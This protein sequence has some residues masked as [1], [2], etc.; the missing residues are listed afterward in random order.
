MTWSIFHRS[1][2]QKY[3]LPNKVRPIIYCGC[4]FTTPSVNKRQYGSII[5]KLQNYLHKL[6]TRNETPSPLGWHI[7]NEFPGNP[8]Q[9]FINWNHVLRWKIY[10]E[11]VIYNGVVSC[12]Q[13]QLWI[14]GWRSYYK[15][16]LFVKYRHFFEEIFCCYF[17]LNCWKG[18][19]CRKWLW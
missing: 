8:V 14:Q 1:V 18:S 5:W 13:K 4:G 16:T 10:K 19:K 15:S 3:L 9:I 17:A 6:V 7:S 12:S 2:H 11:N